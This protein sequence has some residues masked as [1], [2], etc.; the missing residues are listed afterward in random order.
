[1]FIRFGTHELI[2]WRG[3]TP[4]CSS[5]VG[6]QPTDQQFSD[7]ATEIQSCKIHV[8]SSILASVGH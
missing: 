8:S 7:K 5:K 1:M 3:R 6:V 4:P 2:T